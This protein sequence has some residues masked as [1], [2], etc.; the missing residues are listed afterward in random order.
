MV[1]W[2]GQVALFTYV[3]FG[4]HVIALIGTYAL[5]FRLGQWLGENAWAGV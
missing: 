5:L 1:A 2:C 3:F 4:F